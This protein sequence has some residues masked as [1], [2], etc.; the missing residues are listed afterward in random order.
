MC[1]GECGQIHEHRPAPG[2][3]VRV[4][5]LSA[6]V[7]RVVSSL[8]QWVHSKL[9]HTA[10]QTQTL[11]A[12][13]LPLLLLLLAD[14]IDQLS[15]WSTRSMTRAMADLAPSDTHGRRHAILLATNCANSTVYFVRKPLWR[16]RLAAHRWAARIS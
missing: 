5:R 8:V 6:S 3:V 13:L 16:A 4:R 1:L 12:L 9:R 15:V 7:C 14:T 2:T 10:T 11:G